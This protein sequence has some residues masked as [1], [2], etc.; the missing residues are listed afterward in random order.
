[1]ETAS[2][3]RF[4]SCSQCGIELT[5]IR[6]CG[7]CDSTIYCNKTCQKNHWI[8][9]HKYECR[10]TSSLLSM[11]VGTEQ[12]WNMDTVG[13]YL[14]SEKFLEAYGQIHNHQS[15]YILNDGEHTF[16]ADIDALLTKKQ[17]PENL[18]VLMT[19]KYKMS[20]MD[21]NY[22]MVVIDSPN[23]VDWSYMEVSKQ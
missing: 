5:V 18:D 9:G 13:P 19:I 15:Q 2:I 8:S 21:C 12:P 7:R 17:S 20:I 1:M 10:K 6:K 3:S 14:K 11:H 22:R 4:I 16:V 23:G